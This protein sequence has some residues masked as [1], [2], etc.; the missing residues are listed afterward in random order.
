MEK[1]D[2]YR[3]VHY[4]SR[5]CPND[6]L[7]ATADFYTYIF[8]NASDHF[9]VHR[10]TGAGLGRS[11]IPELAGSDEGY[12]PNA[13]LKG[14]HA[15]IYDG[16]GYGLWHHGEVV[17]KNIKRKLG[18]DGQLVVLINRSND[19]IGGFSFGRRCT[20]EE[21]LRTE[22]WIDPYVYS[23]LS[24]K[25]RFERD[26]TL[27]LKGINDFL[28][29]RKGNGYRYDRADLD[30]PVYCWNAT[31]IAPELQGKGHMRAINDLFFRSIPK[32]WGDL[33]LLGEASDKKAGPDARQRPTNLEQFQRVG[34][35]ETIME[36]DRDLYLIGA[37]VERFVEG[38]IKQTGTGNL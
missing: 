9:F 32:E 22:E 29:I 30:T 23:D 13:V 1:N 38:F 2:G 34:G 33:L 36:L 26:G 21:A 16:K 3:I 31:G 19:Q 27:F 25:E 10:G 7:R 11:D 28:D 4:S 5:D 14:L 24:Q 35:A 37:P 15:Q 20:L 17:L 18:R 6:V 12:V 8:N